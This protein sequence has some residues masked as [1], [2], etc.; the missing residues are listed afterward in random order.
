MDY[1]EVPHLHEHVAVKEGDGTSSFALEEQSDKDQ[2]Q[3]K[4]YKTPILELDEDQA[5]AYVNAIFDTE[6]VP[7]AINAI[8][9]R[10]SWTL[11]LVA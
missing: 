4:D 8:W 3:S 5:R 1:Q 11:L 2:P 6:A 9:E 7:E 10:P